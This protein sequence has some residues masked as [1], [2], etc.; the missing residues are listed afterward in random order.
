MNPDLRPSI[1]RRANGSLNR[2]RTTELKTMLRHDTKPAAQTARLFSEK[3]STGIALESALGISLCDESDSDSDPL[4][5]DSDAAESQGGLDGEESPSVQPTTTEEPDW[6]FRVNGPNPPEYDTDF[7]PMSLRLGRTPRVLYARND[8]LFGELRSSLPY[9]EHIAAPSCRHDGGYNGNYLSADEARGCRTVQCIFPKT[10][11][12]TPSPVDLDFEREG[13]YHLTGVARF[14]PNSGIGLRFAPAKQGVDHINAHNSWILADAASRRFL[15]GK[16]DIAN[17]FRLRNEYMDDRGSNSLNAFSMLNPSLSPF[18]DGQPW[19][20]KFGSEYLAANPL[21][22]PSFRPILD[23]AISDDAEFDVNG[24][25]FLTSTRIVNVS[26]APDLFQRLSL[27]LKLKIVSHLNSSA[28]A[29]LR[30]CS[31][32][33]THLPISLW[34]QLITTEM[35]WIYEAWSSDPTPYYWATVN[36][37]DKHQAKEAWEKFDEE[38][39]YQLGVMKQEAPEI[40]DIWAENKLSSWEWPEHPDRREFL[41]LSP[42]RLPPDRTNWYQLYCDISKNKKLI[43]GLRNRERVW[44]LVMTFIKDIQKI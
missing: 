31:R 29:S 20:H 7:L 8:A 10:S 28:I 42:I 6:T 21:F 23:R 11:T 15:G 19:I 40:A 12:W 36:A 33:F 32:A 17:L 44:N 27:E 5:Y 16:V 43:N 26:A 1:D 13:D 22:I 9:Y 18:Q 37:D 2:S 4:E 41:A 3:L 25:P 14:M 38:F 24:S 35:P 34:R 39:N 30:L